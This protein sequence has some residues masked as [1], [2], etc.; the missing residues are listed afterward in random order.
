MILLAMQEQGI[1][2][3]QQVLKVG[4]SIIDI[5][6]GRNAGCRYSIGITTGAHT[7]EQLASARPDFIINDLIEVLLIVES[8]N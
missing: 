7:Y 2:D 3:A 1:T 5:E 4:D 6:E 8:Q